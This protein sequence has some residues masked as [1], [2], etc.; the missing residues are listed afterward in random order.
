MRKARRRVRY[1]A[2]ILRAA[3][4]KAPDKPGDTPGLTAI[5]DRSPSRRLSRTLQRSAR[6]RYDLTVDLGRWGG[7]PS[8]KVW[9]RSR[10]EAALS[11]ATPKSPN[12]F[13]RRP[14]PVRGGSA[15]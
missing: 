12:V 7:R 15:A 8:L 6:N 5:V 2:S 9:S 13:L 3:L 11:G 14:A 10:V 1:G 4:S